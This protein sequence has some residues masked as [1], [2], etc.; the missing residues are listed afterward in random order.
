MHTLEFRGKISEKI[1]NYQII[2]T[3]N[4][5][6]TEMYVTQIMWAKPKWRDS[7]WCAYP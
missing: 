2:H 1:S 7:R 4:T 6:S 5:E 3:E